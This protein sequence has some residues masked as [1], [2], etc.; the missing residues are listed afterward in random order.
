MCLD[1]GSNLYLGRNLYHMRPT[2][3]SRGGSP[4]QCREQLD[5]FLSIETTFPARPLK[6]QGQAPI[7]HNLSPWC[8]DGLLVSCN[9][10]GFVHAAWRPAA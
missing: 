1:S 7:K 6:C 4:R 8:P 10:R 2:M 3:I 9:N 5:L